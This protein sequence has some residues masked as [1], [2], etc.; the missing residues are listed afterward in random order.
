[1]RNLVFL[2]M[3]TLLINSC[4]P[5]KS[6]AQVESES[7]LGMALS[8]EHELVK[9][10]NR[11]LTFDDGIIYFTWV[12]KDNININSTMPFNQVMVKDTVVDKPF[13][14]FRWT[15][16]DYRYLHEVFNDGGVFYVMI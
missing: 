12:S 9:M 13:V 7:K 6:N 16:T 11:Y 5:K 10:N 4:C 1:M 15:P 14:K 3:V 2:I 8:G